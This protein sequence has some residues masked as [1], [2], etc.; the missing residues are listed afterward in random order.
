MLLAHVVEVGHSALSLGL[1]VLKPGIHLLVDQT[2]SFLNTPVDDLHVLLALI[3]AH[4][5]EVAVHGLDESAEKLVDLLENIFA[6]PAAAA[7]DTQL[8]TD[9]VLVQLISLLDLPVF[10]YTLLNSPGQRQTIPL[11]TIGMNQ[12]APDS[13][14]A[15]LL[16]F[17]VHLFANHLVATIPEDRV[18]AITSV[19][20]GVG[21]NLTPVSIPGS[22]C[23]N[24]RTIATTLVA[25]ITAFIQ[26]GLLLA[27]GAHALLEFVLPNLPNTIGLLVR[28]ELGNGG[29]ACRSLSDLVV[30]L[31]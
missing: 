20:L 17:V 24:V 25:R 5:L 12:Y 10:V 21:S 15:D 28:E 8:L 13:I 7:L 3:F 2:A 11:S 29:E 19:E 27:N 23:N 6:I 1:H 14:A 30:L 22:R 16:E 9:S 26:N 31:V 18:K 4:V